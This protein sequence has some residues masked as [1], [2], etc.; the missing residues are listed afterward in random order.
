[1]T[2]SNG[3]VLIEVKRMLDENFRAKKTE[4]VFAVGAAAM[5]GSDVQFL[6]AVN[7]DIQTI[8]AILIIAM[9]DR[10]HIR[11]IILNT[12]K[13]YELAETTPEGRELLKMAD[14][15]FSEGTIYNSRKHGKSNDNKQ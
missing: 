11:D 4:A 2:K 12:A 6:K 8:M 14:S 9:R 7:G 15:M 5:D 1:M 13:A 3:Q 10:E